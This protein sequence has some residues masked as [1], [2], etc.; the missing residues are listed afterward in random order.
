MMSNFVLYGIFSAVPF[1]YFMFGWGISFLAI[2]RYSLSGS[3]PRYTLNFFPM[4]W[5]NLPLPEPISR[6]EHFLESLC[7]LILI[8]RN[9]VRSL[10]EPVFF[11]LKRVF[12]I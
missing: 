1:L 9:F 8:S 11:V 5:P 7:F 3:I 10:F 4:R 12:V 2:F 6:I